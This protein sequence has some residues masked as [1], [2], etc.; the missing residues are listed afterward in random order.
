[1]FSS[2]RYTA[3]HFQ[4]DREQNKIKSNLVTSGNQKDTRNTLQQLKGHFQHCTAPGRQS[5]QEDNFG[6]PTVQWKMLGTAGTCCHIH[7]LSFG[8]SKHWC[9]AGKTPERGQWKWQELRHNHLTQT[10]TDL[11]LFLTLPYNSTT[12]IFQESLVLLMQVLACFLGTMEPQETRYG[13]QNTENTFYWLK[14][15][16]KS[17]KSNPVRGYFMLVRTD[18]PK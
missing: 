5:S 9:A 6:S 7:F 8:L 13:P 17:H 1:M 4:K 2:H 3:D 11:I 18:R 15:L 14:K 10:F 16:Q 12:N